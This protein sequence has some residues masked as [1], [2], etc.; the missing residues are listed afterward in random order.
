MQTLLLAGALAIAGHR[1]QLKV[2]IDTPM[3][4]VRAGPQPH[5]NRDYDRR[6]YRSYGYDRGYDGGC[7][8]VT[9][10]RDYGSVRGV[11]RC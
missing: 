3:G 11:R 10:E 6:G 8:T 2:A 4:G 1:P 5:C 9:I 7:R